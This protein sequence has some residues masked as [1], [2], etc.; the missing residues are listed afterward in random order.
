M[1]DTIEAVARAVCAAHWADQYG[2]TAD[3][4]V[5]D[6]EWFDWQPEAQAAI[7]A[8]IE[9]AGDDETARWLFNLELETSDTSLAAVEGFVLGGEV[10]KTTELK[11]LIERLTAQIAAMKAEIERLTEREPQV[12]LDGV[13]AGI[14]AAKAAIKDAGPDD[15]WSHGW[16]DCWCA[17]RALDAEVIAK[18]EG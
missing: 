7:T 16:E 4:D 15:T 13:R 14:E 2:Q 5:V 17:I 8:L 11:A 1:T 10:F 9:G 18:G 3:A 12:K 6:N